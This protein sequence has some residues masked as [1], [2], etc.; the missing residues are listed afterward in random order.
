VGERTAVRRSLTPWLG[1]AIRARRHATGLSQEALAEKA[2]LHRTYIG[3]VER[4]ER[5]VSVDKLDQIATALAIRA[6]Q[7]LQQAE[8][9]REAK[10]RT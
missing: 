7:L 8:R 4:A 9:M 1:S 6:S 2:R 5:N 3:M 10:A